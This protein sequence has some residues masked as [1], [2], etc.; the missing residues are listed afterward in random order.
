MVKE[1]MMENGTRVNV[2][3]ISF[4]WQGTLLWTESG[5][6]DQKWFVVRPDSYGVHARRGSGSRE[7]SE[8]L[9]RVPEFLNKVQPA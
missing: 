1:N 7:Y 3:E 5:Y 2:K 4:E 9:I 6:G 8:N